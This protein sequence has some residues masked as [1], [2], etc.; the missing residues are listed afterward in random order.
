[1]PTQE[2]VVALGR[3]AANHLWQS[4][5]FAAVAVL[6]ALALRANHARVRYW[7][8]MAASVKFLVPF[9]ALAAVGSLLRR[10]L[11]P[12]TPVA[13]LPIVME[14]I[15][16]PF[17]PVPRDVLGVAPSAPAPGF[18]HL[19]PGFL[20]ALWFCGFATVLIYGWTRWRRVAAVVR[21]STPLREGRE[22]EAL[23]RVVVRQAG[24]LRRVGNPPKR[25]LPT[26]AQLAKLPH[27]DLVS[28]TAR[29]E[30]GIFGIFHPILWLPAGI[31]DRLGDAELEAILAHELCHAR[32]RD[33]LAAAVHMAVEAVFWFHPLV[34]WLGAR[35]VEERERACDEEVVRLGGEPQVYAESILKVCE[36]YLASPVACAAG[37]TGGE[38]KKRIEGI[39]TNRFTRKLSFGKK[40]MLAAA[41]IMFIALPIGVSL[42]NPKGGRAQSLAGLAAPPVRV[43]A[44]SAQKTA[45]PSQL[46]RSPGVAD[47]RPTKGADPAPLAFEAASVRPAP[48]DLRGIRCT[49]GPGTSDPGLLTCENYSL[50]LLVMM[51]YNLRSFQLDAPAWMD[52]VRYNVV[53]RIPP[54]TDRR[55]F[56]LMQQRLLAER[57]GLQVHFEEK[58]MTVYELTEAKGGTKLKESQEPSASVKSEAVWRPPASGPPVRIM[59]Y[60]SRKGDSVADLANFLADQLGRP[61]RDAT[62]LR[63]RYDYSLSFLM[64][65]GGRAAG[66]VTSNGSEP[67]FGV[68]LIDAVRQQLGLELK[69]T[70]GQAE[71]LVVDHAEKV[72]TEN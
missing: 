59:A 20:L 38:L 10:W 24:S 19:L 54:G 63:D 46:P 47:Q 21:A 29:L 22:V 25:R 72:P 68:G 43:V 27:I 28:S 14:Q 58:D 35:L 30:P 45:Q 3:L 65:P 41:G 62:G 8:W 7:L 36:F 17:A 13:R 39:M 48:P 61:V 42:M 16:Q 33:N 51:A 6:L 44:Q 31:G 50:Y 12:P 4:T 66:P 70:K 32:R 64:D 2:F 9:S 69:T 26:G 5:G 37:V 71:I 57:W 1:M 67:E 15:V 18:A 52:T 11:V 60:V 40:L 23:R 34:W 55:Q 49:G 53:A 56:G